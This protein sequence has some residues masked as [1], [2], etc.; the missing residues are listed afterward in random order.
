MATRVPTGKPRGRPK[1]CVKSGGRVAGKSLDKG[2]RIKIT[3][4]MAGSILAVF[5]RLG[6]E[7][8]LYRWAKEN[9]T[10]YVTNCL[11]RLMPPMPKDGDGDTTYNTQV[12]VGNANM[13]EFEAARRVAFCLSKAAYEGGL[14]EAEMTPQQACAVP[15][16]QAP[17]AVPDTMPLLTPEPEPLDDDRARWASEIPLT[18]EERRAN[19]LVR[20]TREASLETYAGGSAQQGHGSVQRPTSSRK[21]TAAE[22]CRRRNRRDDL[23]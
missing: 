14:I 6:G 22:L 16:W 2:E 8:F 18:L 12:N 1:G 13:G 19:A 5:E 21:L 7:D 20:E 15:R 17:D 11:A 10:A 23:L 3:S 9:Q 4:A